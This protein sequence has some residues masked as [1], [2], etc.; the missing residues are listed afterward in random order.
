MGLDQ[1]RVREAV[2]INVPVCFLKIS[3]LVPLP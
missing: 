2:E 3:A 1:L